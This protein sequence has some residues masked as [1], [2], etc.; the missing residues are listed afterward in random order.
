MGPE[1]RSQPAG[2]VFALVLDAQLV[3]L[4]RHEPAVRRDEDPIHLHD[5]RVA[6]R[7]ARSL[8]SAGRDVFPDAHLASISGGT[9]LC[10]CLVAG[11]PTSPVWAGEIQRPG[12][13]M[14]IDVVGDD[15][16]TLAPRERG[17]LVCRSA[18]PSMPLGFW[19]DPG[20]ERYQAA[21]FET[22]FAAVLGIGLALTFAGPG[23]AQW[24]GL[25]CV[26]LAL[27]GA[28]IGLFLALRGIAPNTLP[29]L[30]Y[31]VALVVLLVAGLVVAWRLPSTG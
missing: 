18:F 12:L 8:V 4:R 31:H 11:D 23:L 26:L 16:R 3:D 29:D 10:G 14:A 6:L 5:H 25:V 1:D 28:S 30:V 19:N 15:G 17:E 21:Y 9:D 2:R 13:G 27:G 24:G 22:T 7:R 20:D